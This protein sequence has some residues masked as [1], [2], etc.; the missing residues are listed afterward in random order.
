MNEADAFSRYIKWRSG[1][2]IKLALFHFALILIFDVLCIYSLDFVTASVVGNSAITIGIVYALCI[3]MS[4]IG[5]TFYYSHRITQEE[6]KLVGAS[7][8]KQD[9][10]E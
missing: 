6:M 1:F 10:G 9:Q 2:I 7:T 8:T 5:F 3:V 4:V